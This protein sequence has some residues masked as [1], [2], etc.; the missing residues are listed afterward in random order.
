MVTQPSCASVEMTDVTFEDNSC[1]GVCFARLSLRNTLQRLTL[2][3]NAEISAKRDT[4]AA[5]SLLSLPPASETTAVEMHVDDNNGTAVHMDEAVLKLS[6]SSFSGNHGRSVIVLEQAVNVTITHSTFQRNRAVEQSGGVLRSTST[7]AIRIEDSVFVDN[8]ATGGGAMALD[9]STVELIRCR[10]EGNHATAAGGALSMTNGSAFRIEE[11]TFS[12]NQAEIGGA[13]MVQNAEE[14]SIGAFGDAP[15][16]CA[17]PAL[18]ASNASPLQD[19]TEPT[20]PCPA[21]LSSVDFDVNVAVSGGAVY[22]SEASM[23]LQNTT[24][25]ECYTTTGSGGGFFL[26]DA[27]LSMLSVQFTGTRA[28]AS[29]GGISCAGTTTVTGHDVTFSHSTAKRFGGGIFATERCRLEING[30]R[31]IENDATGSGGGIALRRQATATLRETIF[32][33]NNA[34]KG[35]ALWIKASTATILSSNFTNNT[36]VTG[37]GSIAAR[38]S[39]VTVNGSE[40]RGDVTYV[41]GGSFDVR[42]KTHL[43]IADTSVISSATSRGDGSGG[44]FLVE[45]SLVADGLHMQACTALKYGGAVLAVNSTI[46]CTACQFEKNRA[47]RG[48]GALSLAAPMSSRIPYRFRRCIFQNNT[49]SEGGPHIRRHIRRYLL[50][51]RRH[52]L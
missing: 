21:L 43:S 49:A 22:L 42:A 46:L 6:Q 20:V 41:D 17:F 40:F 18:P 13:V 38:K 15:P 39:D 30:S 8:E 10:F 47:N 3:Q 28:D 34:T 25:T 24:V 36:A 29:G 48:A 7:A 44:M 1:S 51:S 27:S 26:R 14:H 12:R 32:S 4:A 2:A 9:H 31:V 19:D 23:A 35:G 37:G 52:S 5:F 45:S 33:R 16:S 11:T 50:V